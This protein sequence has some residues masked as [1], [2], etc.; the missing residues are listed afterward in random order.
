MWLEYKS[1]WYWNEG[2]SEQKGWGE[3]LK[4]FAALFNTYTKQ[5]DEKYH[6][7]NIQK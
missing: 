2:D 3:F 6:S 5:K 7:L 1:F 4:D